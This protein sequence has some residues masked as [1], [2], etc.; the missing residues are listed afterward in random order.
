[1]PVRCFQCKTA[2]GGWGSGRKHAL[3]TGHT[4]QPG[5][6]C[7]KCEE[8]FSKHQTCRTHM[9]TCTNTPANILSQPTSED[10]S[11]GR[12]TA[13]K[14]VIEMM[15]CVVCMV[16]IVGSEAVEAH[17]QMHRKELGTLNDKTTPAVQHKCA[18]CKLKWTSAA[19]LQQ[20]RVSSSPCKA[21]KVC[22]P[23][24]LASL[25]DHYKRKPLLHP[26]CERCGV[27]FVSW[28]VWAEHRP[29][30][31]VPVVAV[32]GGS[33]GSGGQAVV[34]EW[35]RAKAPGAEVETTARHEPRGPSPQPGVVVG[36]VVSETCPA[37]S[38]VG[39]LSYTVPAPE[40]SASEPGYLEQGLLSASDA[41][42]VP[43]GDAPGGD[44]SSDVSL[45]SLPHTPTASLQS[46]PSVSSISSSSPS[47]TSDEA[48]IGPV[49]QPR[50]TEGRDVDDAADLHTAL[51]PIR[52]W[53]G[54]HAAE[55]A[56]LAL[57]V[58]AASP[59]VK[60]GAESSLVVEPSPD[61]AAANKVGTSSAR[62]PQTLPFQGTSIAR[63]GN[64]SDALAPS[65]PPGEQNP[66]RRI[67]WHCRSPSCLRD[68]CVKP[69]ATICGHVFCH[70]CFMREIETHGKCPVCEKLFLLKLDVAVAA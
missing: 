34:G 23:R 57:H 65:A 53:R 14:P 21:C 44:V 15:S 67:S 11:V 8:T 32:G 6:Y 10:S 20:H 24:G 60:P 43:T 56:A 40:T 31:V 4:W 52:R 51:D 48:P 17:R 30:C 49:D 50:P 62:P 29:T 41:E 13:A 16:H 68:P 55:K 46:V 37:L 58:T 7:S 9:K 47:P 39:S 3:L 26:M 22:V 1:M 69:I 19:A 61:V 25:Q 36:E 45:V 33:E 18:V 2:V 59:L 63:Q 70:G 38:S 42:G 12:Q 27:A 54:P 28:T 5:Y 35:T 66:A 64:R